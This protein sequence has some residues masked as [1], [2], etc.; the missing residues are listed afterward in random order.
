ME[1]R[2]IIL[3]VIGLLLLFLWQAMYRA[4]KQ[5]QHRVY[6]PTTGTIDRVV[7]SDGGNVR[8]IVGF[9]DS[10]GNLILARTPTYTSD[11]PSR[12][13]GDVVRIGYNKSSNGKYCVVLQEGTDVVCGTSIP[14]FCCFLVLLGG[15]L[16]VLGGLLCI[17]SK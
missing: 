7:F 6:V 12:N 5:E 2:G 8:Y 15:F 10:G 13:L 9:L 4:Y 11:T 3:C 1:E 17:F 14:T 16:F